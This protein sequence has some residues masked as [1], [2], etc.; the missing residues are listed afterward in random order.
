LY[1]FIINNLKTFGNKFEFMDGEEMNDS[2]PVEADA[3]MDPTA[4]AQ[5]DAPADSPT[6]FAEG[7]AEG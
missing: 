1:L 2:V 6:A 4:D 5:A 7:E 3:P